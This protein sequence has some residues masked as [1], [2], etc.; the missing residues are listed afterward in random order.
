MLLTTDRPTRAHPPA[1]APSPAAVRRFVLPLSTD[2]AAARRWPIATAASPDPVTLARLFDR[3][4]RPA[5][6]LARPRDAEY[7]YSRYVD[8]VGPPFHRF[9]SA[10]SG[11]VIVRI[12]RVDGSLVLRLAE[13]L[14]STPAAWAG[15]AD[16]A[17][18]RLVGGALGWAAARGCVAAEHLCRS[19]RAGHLL[20]PLGF[21]ERG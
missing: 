10:A 12:G 8:V 7:W 16:P 15:A 5:F 1:A 21:A 19:R 6:P 2:D 3:T 9:G 4:V 18:V 17:F 11:A 20:A 13:L 14:P